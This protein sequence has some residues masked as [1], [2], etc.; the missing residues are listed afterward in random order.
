MT[1]GLAFIAGE[2]TTKAY[3]DFPAIVRGTVMSVGYTDATYGFDH[4][5][6]AVISSHPRADPRHR[7]GSGHR[8]APATRA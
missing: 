7:H 2:I 6:C 3:V 1:T 8:A 4:E 5:T